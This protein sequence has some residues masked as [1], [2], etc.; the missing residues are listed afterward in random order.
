ML[1]AYRRYTNV[2]PGLSEKNSSG[3]ILVSAQDTTIVVGSGRPFATMSVNSGRGVNDLSV[4]SFRASRSSTVGRSAIVR[5]VDGLVKWKMCNRND[6]CDCKVGYTAA[7]VGDERLLERGR[8]NGHTDFAR[9]RYIVVRL[10]LSNITLLTGYI[11]TA[12][13]LMNTMPSP[14]TLVGAERRILRYCQSREQGLDKCQVVLKNQVPAI[15]RLSV[16]T[17]RIDAEL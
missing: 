1:T 7:V 9:P 11:S 3:Q 13:L 17:L 16:I 8:C 4:A 12:F 6:R 15:R 14:R 5:G 2:P 10:M